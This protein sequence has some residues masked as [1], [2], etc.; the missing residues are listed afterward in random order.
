MFI[1]I[2]GIL[3]KYVKLGSHDGGTVH[4]NNGMRHKVV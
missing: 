4:F 3:I 1:T 2:R